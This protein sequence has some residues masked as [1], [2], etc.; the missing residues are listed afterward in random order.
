MIKVRLWNEE[1]ET[2]DRFIFGIWNLFFLVEIVA[3]DIS[4][5]M[6]FIIYLLPNVPMLEPAFSPPL[7]SFLV[8]A[9]Q[10]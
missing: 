5:K 7:Q 4:S 9:R 10:N 2:F 8:F 3:Y 6:I 1:E